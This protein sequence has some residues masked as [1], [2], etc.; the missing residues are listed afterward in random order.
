[1]ENP[2][3]RHY[4]VEQP[5]SGVSYAKLAVI[6]GAVALVLHL[7]GGASVLDGITKHFSRKAA[8]PE[9][10]PPVLSSLTIETEWG[11]TDGT[12]SEGSDRSSVSVVGKAD[13]MLYVEASTSDIGLD[14]L[15]VAAG[16]IPDVGGFFDGGIIRYRITALPPEQMGDE[17][18]CDHILFD[19]ARSRLYLGFDLDAF[20]CN[21]DQTW[22]VPKKK[23]KFG[24][25]PSGVAALSQAIKENA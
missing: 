5:S 4:I 20:K 22:K 12:N 15:W 2:N 16:E 9:S 3:P 14:E 13:G 24:C 7:L 1:M 18:R 19:G 10:V 11:E 21:I 17:I 25:N 23:K 6:V 8:A